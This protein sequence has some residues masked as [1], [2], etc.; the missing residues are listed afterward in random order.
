[1]TPVMSTDDAI[2]KGAGNLDARWK[3][4][5]RS[6]LHIESGHNNQETDATYPF[7]L[8]LRTDTVTRHLMTDLQLRLSESRLV[9]LQN[10][11]K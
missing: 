1:M 10:L 5:D 3:I 11:Q 9:E 8:A 2:E 6:F 4:S 7:H